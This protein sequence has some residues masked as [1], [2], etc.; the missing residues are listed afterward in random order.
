MSVKAIKITNIITLIL[1]YW[2]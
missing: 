2:K 1:Y